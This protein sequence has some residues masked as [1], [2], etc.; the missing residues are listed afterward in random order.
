LP[1]WARASLIVTGGATVA[2]NARNF[3]LTREVEKQRE[4]QELKAE[5]EN[6]ERAE[7]AVSGARRVKTT[8]VSD[9]RA[10]RSR[11]GARFDR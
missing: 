5:V 1:W 4:A 9:L 11:M 10:V 6:L 7:A 3:L 8:D 2:Y